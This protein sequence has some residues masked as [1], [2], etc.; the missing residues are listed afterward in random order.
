[1]S[2]F[3][4]TGTTSATP[5]AIANAPFWPAIAPAS[6]R[7]SMRL[8]GTVTDARLRHAIVAAMLA[9]NDALDAW[10]Q[11]QQAAGYAAL[12][13][14]PSTTVDG[15]SRRVQLYLRAVACATAVE[16]A[17][18]YR[19]FD[20]TDSANQ[21]ADDLSPSITELRRDQ[22]WAVRDLQNLPRNTAEL[23]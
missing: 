18:R 1:M 4:A 16:V 11:A 5:D 14:V 17:E 15:V 9:V 6:V 2:G 20:A 8:D 12:A 13:D 23:I 3:T 22:R 19:S 21:R 7:A 10:A